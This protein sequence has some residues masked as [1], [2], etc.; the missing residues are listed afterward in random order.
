MKLGGISM[1][2]GI[3]ASSG[4]AQAKVYRLEH[5]V[6]EIEK[7]EANSSEEL[8]KFEDALEKTREDIKN[9]QAKAVGKLSD[10]E[11][12]I[13][14]AHLEF[15]NDPGLIDQV[16]AMINSDSVNA[17]FALDSVANT[18][19]TMFEAMEDDY[20]RERAADIK[21]VTYRIKAHIKEQQ[22]S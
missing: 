16:V 9:I 19:I 2:K 18:F 13:F 4:Y 14:D 10:E 7:L 6:L 20:F 22:S 3:A 21:D 12:A 8:I 17:E 1:L 15:T 11:L 5:P